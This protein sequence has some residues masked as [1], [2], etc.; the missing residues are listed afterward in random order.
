MISFRDVI[1]L[2]SAA[3]I[4]F[5]VALFIA[6]VA[7]PSGTLL[8]GAKMG[9]LASLASGFIALYLGRLLRVQRIV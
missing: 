8:D 3:G 2:G 6:T 1:T 5:T 9:A 4:G 7:L